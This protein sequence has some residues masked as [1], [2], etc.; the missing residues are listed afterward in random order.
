MTVLVAIDPTAPADAS[1]IPVS[2]DGESRAVVRLAFDPH[3]ASGGVLELAQLTR[4]TAAAVR[5]LATRITGP[6]PGF[7]S[8]SGSGNTVVPELADHPVGLPQ[9]LRVPALVVDV[10]A[11]SS[12]DLSTPRGRPPGLRRSC[13]RCPRW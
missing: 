2:F 1:P 13:R 10:G 7:G 6:R 9:G 5:E 11:G 3:L 12:A 4:P 8:G